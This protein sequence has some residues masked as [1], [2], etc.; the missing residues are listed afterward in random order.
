MY[1]KYQAKALYRLI[2]NSTISFDHKSYD[3]AEDIPNII[4]DGRRMNVFSVQFIRNG[5][6]LCCELDDKI[7]CEVTIKLFNNDYEIGDT[8]FDEILNGYG[9]DQL[10]HDIYYETDES[11]DIGDYELDFLGLYPEN[12]EEYEGLSKNEMLADIVKTM[13]SNCTTSW[14]FPANTFVSLNLWGNPTKTDLRFLFIRETSRVDGK[15]IIELY[16]IDDERD[17]EQY[18]DNLEEFSVEEIRT[19]Y[20]IFKK[21]S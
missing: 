14:A 17:E 21:N 11:G 1:L 8:E 19:I 7:L 5:S 10:F 15:T 12:L 6:A 3:L 18:T 13:T 9:L 4:H 16:S 20:A 2:G